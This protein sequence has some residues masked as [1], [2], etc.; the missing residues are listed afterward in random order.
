MQYSLISTNLTFPLLKPI[1]AVC[2]F[3]RV[4]SISEQPEE[5]LHHQSQTRSRDTDTIYGPKKC[6]PQKL[7]RS[8][9]QIIYRYLIDF[10]RVAS[11]H[12]GTAAR[13]QMRA[14]GPEPQRQRH[15]NQEKLA[16]LAAL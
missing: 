4:T 6:S 13:L 10:L 8:T 16:K 5:Q 11:D 9:F 3:P 14:D 2:T 7:Q 12:H 15:T 1:G